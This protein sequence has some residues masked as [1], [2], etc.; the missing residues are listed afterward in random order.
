MMKQLG[1]ILLAMVAIVGTASAF[2]F[3]SD[4]NGPSAVGLLED[5]T[6]TPAL[7]IHNVDFQPHTF[8]ITATSDSPF[9]TAKPVVKKMVLN[10]YESTQIG[11]D[12]HSTDDA[13]HDTYTV[14]VKVDADGQVKTFPILV[15][16]GSNPYLTVGTFSKNVCGNEYVDS[17]SFSVKNITNTDTAVSIHAEQPILFPTFED[18]IYDLPKGE[19]KTL[20]ILL[21]TSP[22]NTGTYEGI[23]Y[24]TNNQIVVAR[25]FSVKVNDCPSLIEKTV[26]LTLPKKPKDLVKLQTTLFP[27]TLKNL[28]DETQHV[29]VSVDSIIP[30]GAF[31][32]VLSPNETQTVDVPFM[33][34][35]S[36]K[37][38]TYSVNITATANGFSI[39]QSANMK[40]LA[41]S[42]IT[43]TPVTTIYEMFKGETKTMIVLVENKGD[44]SQNISMSM[45]NSIPGVD[46]AFTPSTFTL[47]AGKSQLVQL[48]VV[49]DESANIESVNNSII[50]NGTPIQYIP[51]TFQLVSPENPLLT[52][53]KV[54]SA[55]SHL[56]LVA[57]K[58]V[59]F[60]V[61]VENPTDNSVLG[62]HFKM[63][64][65][66]GSGLILISADPTQ[67]IAPHQT[68][69]L[70]FTLRADA[71][72]KPGAYSPILVMESPS[73]GVSVPLSVNVEQPGFFSG[74][75]GF[76]SLL[77]GNASAVGLI[78]LLVILGLW[79]VGRVSKKSPAWTSR[80]VK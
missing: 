71:S 8:T 52:D 39:S 2:P 10:G 34:D 30:S 58:D 63:V 24:V 57:G 53:L 68:K 13:E 44:V 60:D 43:T 47:A 48:N 19:Q 46:Y 72:T 45:Q 7:D 16:I 59:P 74:I 15:Y 70:S 23:L 50:I 25:S 31:T 3:T 5:M 67:S 37:S 9:I 73:V 78:L 12:I 69:T 56:D 35:L 40:V 36:V 38:G 11:L 6:I 1:L 77:G 76:F 17:I 51:F 41:F 62:L 64:G 20:S 75:T 4:V 26:S 29:D 21:N 32:I 27:I 79:F 28:T 55:P 14:T 80:W 22:P 65:V 54:L 66:K 18:E 33:P 61:I 42:Y 49:V